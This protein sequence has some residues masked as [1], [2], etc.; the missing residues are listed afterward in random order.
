[1]DAAGTRAVSRSLPLFLENGIGARRIELTDAKDPDEYLQV[2]GA[3][4]L[5]DAINQ[6]EPL[7]FTAEYL[8]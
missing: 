7:I 2:N 4:A 3:D 1:M 6:A 8:H 5:E